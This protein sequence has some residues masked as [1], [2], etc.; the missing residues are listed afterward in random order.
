MK[1]SKVF[2]GSAGSVL[3]SSSSSRS[4]SSF[5]SRNSYKNI[6][7]LVPI[8]GSV[9]VSLGVVVGGALRFERRL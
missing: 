7:S 1:T 2:V 8:A 5:E 4:F 9:T 6:A 3:T